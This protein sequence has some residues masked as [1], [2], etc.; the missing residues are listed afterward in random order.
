[1][2]KIS[3]LVP[4]NILSEI[5]AQSEGNRTAFMVGAALERARKVRREKIDRE[6]IASLE[7]TDDADARVYAEWEGTLSD[8][9]E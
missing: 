1:M 6:I 9:L 3:M 2:A 4:D 5:D 8:G 7:R